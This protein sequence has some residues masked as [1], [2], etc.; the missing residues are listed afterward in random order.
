M[1][2]EGINVVL[3][4]ELAARAFEGWILSEVDAG[5]DTEGEAREVGGDGG[6]GLDRQRLQ[7]ER[8]RQVI[9]SQRRLHDG[10]GDHAG[11]QVADLRWIKT[12]LGDGEGV[13]QDFGRCLS[14]HVLRCPQRSQ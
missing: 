7:L 3:C 10:G 6:Q 8:A 1:A 13:A 4:D 9:E 11:I 2:L 12:C 5:L 14:C